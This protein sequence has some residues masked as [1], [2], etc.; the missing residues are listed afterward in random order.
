MSIRTGARFPVGMAEVFPDGCHL[1]P[2]SI[3]EAIDYDEKTRRRTPAVDKLT[4]KPVFQVRVVDMDPELEGRSREVV[5]KILA[6][7]MPVP[8]TRTPFELVEFEGLV[9][10][11]YVDNGRCQ[12]QGRC[13]A[14]MAFSLRATGIKAARPAAKDV[15]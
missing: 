13:G 5:V 1:V 14:R 2:D 10:T 8:P 7:R 3:T 6:D 11:P 15:A 4:G 12:G 9:V